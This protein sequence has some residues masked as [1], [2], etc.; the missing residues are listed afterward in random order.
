MSDDEKAKLVAI[1]TTVGAFIMLLGKYSA[2]DIKRWADGA[3]E[4]AI[5]SAALHEQGQT[6]TKTV[7]ADR[8]RAK[9]AEG[10]LT[11]RQSIDME[12]S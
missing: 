11:I 7:L 6:D 5:E 1:S 3:K 4:I 8:R 2:Q 12:V 10:V 9:A